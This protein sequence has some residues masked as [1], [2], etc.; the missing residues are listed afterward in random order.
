MAKSFATMTLL[1]WAPEI[2]G[3]GV[4]F[5]VP[6]A[7]KG[8]YIGNADLGG[9]DR[10]DV[11]AAVPG[12]RKNLVLFYMC[13]PRVDGYVSWEHTLDSLSADGNIALHPAELSG[14]H[15]IKTVCE[16]VMPGTKVAGLADK[17]F[18]A[19]VV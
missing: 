18:I 13:E 3:S 17:A 19:N 8:F 16:L 7:F 2:G 15:L 5:G 4:K 6:V 11:V 14:T 10:G 12:E 1:Y 9:F